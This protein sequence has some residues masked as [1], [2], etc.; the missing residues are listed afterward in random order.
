MSGKKELVSFENIRRISKDTTATIH[1]IGI[2]GSSMYS[3][4]RLAMV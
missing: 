1:F 2:G 4:A 3:L